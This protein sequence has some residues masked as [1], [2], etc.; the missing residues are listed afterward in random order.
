VWKLRGA[1]ERPCG[2]KQIPVRVPV[3]TLGSKSHE[4]VIYESNPRE[5]FCTPPLIKQL[6]SKES[7]IYETTRGFL[8]FIGPNSKDALT[9]E[10]KLQKSDLSYSPGGSFSKVLTPTPF[11]FPNSPKIGS[12]FFAVNTSLVT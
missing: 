3:P 9:F 6:Y 7:F 1:E 5:K 2:T 11:L 10:E 4:A 8:N 12:C